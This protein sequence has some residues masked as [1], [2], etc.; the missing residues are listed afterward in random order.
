MTGRQQ[1]IAVQQ[2]NVGSLEGVWDLV[3]FSAFSFVILILA[4]Y[5]T[6]RF[7]IQQPEPAKRII[8]A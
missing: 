6:F 1:A 4:A 8:S 7:Q 3:S 2:L 5:R